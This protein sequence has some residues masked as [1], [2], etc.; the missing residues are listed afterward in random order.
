MTEKKTR[1]GRGEGSLYWDEKRQRF[2]AE[3]TIGYTPAG[4]RIF[5]RGSGKTKTEARAKLKEVMRDRD[6]D[7]NVTDPNFTVAH[8]ATD[9]LQYGLNGRAQSTRKSY[10]I[11]VE[12]HIVASLGA[13]K[14]RQLTAHDV[15]KWLVQ[16]SKTLS[17]RT[18][19]LLHSLLSRIVV[20]AMARDRVKRNVVALCDI[21]TGTGG[22][23]SKSL[24]LEQA[25]AVLAVATGSR[26]RAYIVVSLLTGARTE[27]LRALTWKRVNLDG[28]LV[29]GEQIPP[30][31]EVGT[32]SAREETRKPASHAAPWRYLPAAS[33]HSTPTRFNKART[34][35]QLA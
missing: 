11:L 24:S 18:V 34:S 15:D 14:I 2:I 6:D 5:R 30:T 12:T 10:R 26:Y 20:R 7:L 29:D 35:P 16:E 4:K 1:R 28:R 9:W 31:I 8:A 32:R 3:V 27:E 22:R 19:R 23:P 21:P 13:R 25:K 33:M 17:T